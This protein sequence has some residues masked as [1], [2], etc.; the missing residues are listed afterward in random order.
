MPSRILQPFG[1]VGT[2]RSGRVDASRRFGRRLMLTVDA[3]LGFQSS[4]A[5]EDWNVV[6]YNGMRTE[7][8]E[9][10]S[11]YFVFLVLIGNYVVVNLFIAILLSSFENHRKKQLAK[12]RKLELKEAIRKAE[13]MV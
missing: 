7:V 6:M 2:A 4:G 10:A 1:P 3:R 5:G 11:L 13:L 12:E 8:G 9:W